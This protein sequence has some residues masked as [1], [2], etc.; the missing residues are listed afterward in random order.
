VHGNVIEPP[1]GRHFAKF[2]P[3]EVSFRVSDVL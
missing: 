1:T 3:M 2:A